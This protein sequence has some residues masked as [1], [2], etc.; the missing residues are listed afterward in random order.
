MKIPHIIDQF[1]W[2]KIIYELG[3]G[4]KGIKIG[5]I[6]T[7]NFEPKIPELLNNDSFKKKAEQVAREMEKEDLREEIYRSIVEG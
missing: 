6:T 1:V 2:N 3:A 7:K 4:P 5:K